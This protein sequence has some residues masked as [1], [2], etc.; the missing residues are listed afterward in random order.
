MNFRSR[1]T[2]KNKLT[3]R[4]Q[5]TNFSQSKKNNNNLDNFDNESVDEHWMFP[6]CIDFYEE[7]NTYFYA[8]MSRKN[9][10][11]IFVNK[12]EMFVVDFTPDGCHTKRKL[13]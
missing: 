11:L 4:K 10:C 13:R 2:L 8:K 9:D 7:T 3:N 6:F 5:G 1:E 12:S